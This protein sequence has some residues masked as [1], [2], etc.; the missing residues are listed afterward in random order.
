[1]AYKDSKIVAIIPARGGSKGIPRKNLVKVAGI[2][3]IAYAIKQ[4]I[5]SS[6]I[7]E[8]FVSTEDDEISDVSSYYGASIIKRPIVLS[9]DSSSSIDVL[10][11]AVN[12]IED[13]LN[14]LLDNIICLQATTPTRKIEDIDGAIKL[15]FEKEADSVVSVVESPHSYNPYWA[16][17]LDSGQLR[18]L[19][20]DKKRIT[21]RQ[22][23]PQI[24]YHNGQIFI[25]CK[26]RL[27]NDKD[28]YQGK[29]LPYVCGLENFDN[30]DNYFEL[31]H[32]EEKILSIRQHSSENISI[33]FSGRK[34]GYNHPS[35]LIAEV[36]INHN[37]KLDLARE[38]VD[39][40]SMA[41][42]DAVKFQLF[43]P[44]NVVTYSTPMAEYQKENLG[45]DLSQ[46]DMLAEYV[47]SEK[48]L[49]ILKNYTEKQGL[50]FL[51]TSHSGVEEYTK[52]DR[53]G[54]CAHKVGSGDLMNLSVLRYLASTKKPVII[55]TGM[56][57]LEEVHL[58][59][60][61]MINAGNDKTVFLHCTTDYPCSFS[62]VNLNGMLTM[63]KELGC[64]TGY[65]DHTLG[66]E[67]PIMAVT[68]G[69]CVI[70]KHITLDKSLP[71]PDHKASIEPAELKTMVEQIRNIELAFGSFSKEPTSKEM[72]VATVARKSLVYSRDLKKGSIIEEGDISVK[73]PG[74][75]ISPFCFD[76][77]IGCKLVKAVQ[78]DYLVEE[79]DLEG[80]K[81]S[82]NLWARP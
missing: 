77:V 59:H 71:G 12:F 36:G 18:L 69:A 68:L 66:T 52:L 63:K 56:A 23:L 9:K 26:D 55:S 41:G 75:G 78:R 57:T 20:K 35:F 62:D 25:T 74:T 16:K 60:A 2:P 49:V 64:L 43:N 27:M 81:L 48:D 47:L 24:F 19:F 51:C 38:L 34:V 1:M 65:S 79:N 29:C 28:W 7:D 17:I 80:E 46:R 30:I 22:D 14:I 72:E 8:V 15:F 44:I 32:T 40:A 21:R 50:I 37:G 45:T 4:A 73:R 31:Q 76:M 58:V 67:V 54:V 13:E 11:H 82:L 10:R 70:E 6:Y 39:V 53:M 33:D 3:L 42:V 61:F 5:E